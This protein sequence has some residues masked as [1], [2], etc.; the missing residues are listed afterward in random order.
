MTL[1]KT[2]FQH[3]DVLLHELQDLIEKTRSS[4]AT[5]VNVALTMLYWRIGKRIN[6]E[7]LQGER[8]AC[9]L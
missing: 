6:E 9:G 8:A 3:T 5:T 1:K 4:V 2:L 7:I